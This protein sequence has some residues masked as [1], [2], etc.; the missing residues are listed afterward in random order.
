MEIGMRLDRRAA[1]A[2]AYRAARYGM[3]KWQAWNYA[4]A[5][6]KPLPE[7]REEN[8]VRLALAGYTHSRGLAVAPQPN[9]AQAT[10]RYYYALARAETRS[11]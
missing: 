3:N 4:Q 10:W 7:S 6:I 9:L 8:T 1:V 5:V 11:W 2:Q